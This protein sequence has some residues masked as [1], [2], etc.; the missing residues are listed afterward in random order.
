MVKAWDKNKAQLSVVFEFD[1]FVQAAAFI[2][3]CAGEMERQNHH[4]SIQWEYC[5]IKMQVT[6]HDAGNTLTSKDWDL[7][8]AISRIYEKSF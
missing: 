5:T 2:Q 6:T 1:G 3:E 7:S 8:D 4:A